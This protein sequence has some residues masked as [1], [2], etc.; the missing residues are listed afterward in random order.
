MQ[1]MHPLAWMALLA[2][3][4]MLP[5]CGSP[6][7]D[8]PAVEATATADAQP[9]KDTREPKQVVSD[10]LDLKRKGKVRA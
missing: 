8:G 9:A 6:K 2:S 3:A 5:G 1:R 4:L 10:F 7:S